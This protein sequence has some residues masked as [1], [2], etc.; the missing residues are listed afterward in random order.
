MQRGNA[1]FRAD[2]VGS[3]LR[4]AALKQAR[5][6]R[7]RG[8]IGP[9]DLAALEDREIRRIIAKQEA[10]GLEVATDGE[11]RR[12]WWHY[13]FLGQLSGVDEVVGDHGIQFKGVQ[14]QAKQLRVTGQIDFPADHPMLAHFAFLKANTKAVAKFTIP[15]PTVLHFRLEP[16]AVSNPAY[17][18]Q[19]TFF[20]D[21]AAAYRKAIISA[22]GDVENGLIATKQSRLQEELQGDVV[23]ASRRAYAIS[24]ERLR[25][26]TIDLVTLLS[27]Q[28]NLFQA[29]EILIQSRLN[30]LQSAISLIE[31]LGGGFEVKTDARLRVRDAQ[32]AQPTPVPTP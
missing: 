24:E 22:F 23:A 13:D 32:A 2:V 30:R 27:V 29:E 18:N 25:A 10:L 19:D 8:E 7:A 12:S 14:S 21:L 31:A 3:Y 26:G 1:P 11:F 28:Q 5:A 15:S 4:P 6:Q 9:Q 17:Q 16:G 20:A